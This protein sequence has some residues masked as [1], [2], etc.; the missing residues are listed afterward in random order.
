VRAR[1]VSQGWEVDP[2]LAQVEQRNEGCDF[3]AR[4]P[5]GRE[6]AIEV[7]GWGDPLVDSNGR[8]R[9]AVDINAEQLSRAECDEN[10]RLEIVANLDAVLTSRGHAQ[11]LSLTAAEVRARAVGW[12]YRVNLDDFVARVEEMS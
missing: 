5:A 8:F 7:K 11:C 3:L 2:P 4:S 6:H 1:L 12:R 10:W 9:H